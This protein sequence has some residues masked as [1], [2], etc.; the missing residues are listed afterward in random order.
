[1][2]QWINVQ[3]ADGQISIGNTS[4]AFG[5]EVKCGLGSV[6]FLRRG[7][8]VEVVR[9]SG[10]GREKYRYAIRKNGE[11][12]VGSDRVYRMVKPEEEADPFR[13]L[14]RL[15]NLPVAIL[16]RHNP[17]EAVEF[18]GTW[19]HLHC[20][21]PGGTSSFIE[22]DSQ[23]PISEGE[24]RRGTG[25]YREQSWSATISSATYAAVL[26]EK[27]DS[28]G[29]V[30]RRVWELHIWGNPQV[31]PVAKLICEWLRGADATPEMLEAERHGQSREWMVAQVAGGSAAW[32][33]KIGSEEFPLYHYI[34][35]VRA[36]GKYQ[37]PESNNAVARVFNDLDNDSVIAILPEEQRAY[38]RALLDKEFAVAWLASHAR[39]FRRGEK[40]YHLADASGWLRE[41][42]R[43]RYV[44]Y[45]PLAVL[46][47]HRLF[48][49][50]LVSAT[51]LG[52]PLNLASTK[53]PF[54]AW[55]DVLENEEVKVRWEADTHFFTTVEVEGPGQYGWIETFCKRLEVFRIA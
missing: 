43:D 22:T 23:E 5:D 48:D 14:L 30:Y 25:Y 40:L 55:N 46:N 6:R 13:K 7:N 36:K 53:S 10:S 28:N 49:N 41:V 3:V 20:H 27:A 50:A 19:A 39:F 21:M 44:E 18:R 24:F 37:Y 31:E 12:R 16:H 15:A 51:V 32:M 29:R 11:W 47:R 38:A 8:A 54:N 35:R 26:G 45:G 9:Y 34:D 4:V 33:V 52:E 17:G 42:E 2:S 1:M